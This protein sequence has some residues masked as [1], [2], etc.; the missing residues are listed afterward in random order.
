MWCSVID[1][2]VV[3]DA[4]PSDIRGKYFKDSGFK[5]KTDIGAIVALVEQGHEYLSYEECIETIEAFHGGN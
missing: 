2:F 1:N 5:S 4:T 3:T